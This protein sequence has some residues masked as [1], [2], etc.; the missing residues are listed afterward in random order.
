MIPVPSP[1]VGPKLT[2]RSTGLTGTRFVL[3]ER[4]SI[5]TALPFRTRNRLCAA[6]R[7]GTSSH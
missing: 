5:A 1:N 6:N 4:A 3:A 2:A 7:F